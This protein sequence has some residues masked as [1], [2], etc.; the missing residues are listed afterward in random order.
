[1]SGLPELQKKVTNP[2]QIS[3][4]LSTLYEIQYRN[5]KKYSIGIALSSYNSNTTTT[6][7]NSNNSTNNKLIIEFYIFVLY[8]GLFW[9]GEK[10]AGQ[11]VEDGTQAL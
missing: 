11:D 3:E 4:L 9:R 1:M 2:R 7:Y 8:I 10:Q 5:I 6:T